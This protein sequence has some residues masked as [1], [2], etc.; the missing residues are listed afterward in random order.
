MAEP[1]IHRTDSSFKERANFTLNHQ[2]PFAYY[3]FKF[4]R[5][6]LRGTPTEIERK[7]RSTPTEN[8]FTR[9]VQGKGYG[10]TPADSVAADCCKASPSPLREA[11]YLY[12]EAGSSLVLTQ[13]RY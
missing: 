11:E 1:N 8:I 4:P 6:V 5:M 3:S 10:Q 13:T 9:R 12:L 7:K 2:D